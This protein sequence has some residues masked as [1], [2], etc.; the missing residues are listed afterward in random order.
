MASPSKRTHVRPRVQIKDDLKKALKQVFKDDLVDISDGYQDNIHVLV[1]SRQFDGMAEQAKQD[2]LRAPIDD[3]GL[4][5]D[6]KRL[7]SLVLPLSPAD[8]I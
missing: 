7:I 6:E 4:S 5:E 2:M 8:I 3:S 1:V